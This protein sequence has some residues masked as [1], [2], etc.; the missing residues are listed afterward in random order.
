MADPT[1]LLASTMFLQYSDTPGGTRKS[2]VCLSQADFSG[3][4]TINSDETHCGILKGIG[5]SNNTFTGTAVVDM[6]P[7]ADE[8]SYEDLKAI[9]VAK[10]KKYWHLLMRMTATITAGTAG[11]AHSVTRTLPGRHQNSPSH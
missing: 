1:T 5:N 3:S 6:V 7:D 9:Y 10:T 11:S 4:A 2:A 8:A